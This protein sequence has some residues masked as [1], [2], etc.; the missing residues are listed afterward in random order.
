MFSMFICLFSCILYTE[1][2]QM[3]ANECKCMLC[4]TSLLLGWAILV[5]VSV[6]PLLGHS[7]TMFALV[8]HNVPKGL[9]S[10]L[11]CKFGLEVHI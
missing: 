1:Y 3:G 2:V 8:L 4:C 10:N 7:C 6:L 5:L 11:C 9:T